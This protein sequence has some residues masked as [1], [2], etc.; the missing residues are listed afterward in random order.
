LFKST[1]AGGTWSAINTGLAYPSITTL[2]I[3]PTMPQTIYAVIHGG[4]MFKSTDAGG[5]WSALN[6]G[7]INIAI[8]VLAIDP[9]SPLTIYAGTVGAGVWVHWPP[10]SSLSAGGATE[11][12]TIGA[13]G[14]TRVGYSKLAL[15]SG[16][17]PYGAAVFSYKQ[18][19]ITVAEA[20]V[21]ASP[22]TTSAR[23]FIDYRSGVNAVPGRNDSGTIDIN[24]GIA[25]VNNGSSAANVTYT[26]RGHD[27]YTLSLGHGTID[28]GRHFARFITNLHE[29]ASD[30]SLPPNFQSAVQFGSLEID[31]SQPL[32]V[33]GMRITNNQ[34]GQALITTTP[35]AD[36]TR[37]ASDNPTYFAQFAD[38]GGY[39]TSVVL[40]NTSS[41]DETGTLQIRDNNGVPLVVNQIGGTADSSFRYSIPAGGV[42]HFQTDG[43]SADSIKVGWVQLTPDP[44][45][46]APVGSGVFSYNPGSILVSESGVP[47]AV[48]TKHARV[49]VDLS[50]S[51]DTG[52]A[53]ANVNSMAANVTI[54]AYKTDGVTGVGTGKGP[55]KLA[56]KGHDAKFADQFISDLPAGFT[57][58]LDISSATPFA[59]L[60]V[61]SLTNELGNFLMT[62]FPVADADQAAPSPIVFPQVADGE[63]YVTEFIFL[64]AGQAANTTLNFYDESGAPT[65]LGQ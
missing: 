19:E 65:D 18:N 14:A 23:I 47:A 30:F 59:V 22:P 9:K 49:Y 17:A 11:C 6:T 4:G 63:G 10:C 51:H 57:G 8:S 33:L 26:L 2:A 5:S 35:T 31:S 48:S 53:I 34:M 50:G 24:T 29:V 20:G 41:S 44:S 56:A 62:T 37:P 61:R 12:E 54:N 52:L 45:I 55:L 60:A 42:F 27:G 43:S 46:P 1:E 58:V 25:V 38:G 16:A 40:L 39:T 28:P 64:S 7:L 36:L 3:D 21:P 15:K 13:S 32:S